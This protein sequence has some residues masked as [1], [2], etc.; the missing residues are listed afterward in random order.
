MQEMEVAAM[1]RYVYGDFGRVVVGEG[2]SL[3]LPELEAGSARAPS[4]MFSRSEYQVVTEG[5]K[6]RMESSKASRR[7]G[8]DV[9]DS[10]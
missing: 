8:K 5:W 1:A 9:C 7:H 2:Y 3:L 10:G 6:Y 4:W